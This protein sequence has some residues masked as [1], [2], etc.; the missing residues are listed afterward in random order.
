LIDADRVFGFSG[1]IDW[2]LAATLQPLG[3]R[4]EDCKEIEQLVSRIGAETRAGDHIVFMSN[5]GF[6]GIHQKML[7]YLAAQT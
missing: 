3:S 4:A 1:G 6:G 2:D 5:G 7:D